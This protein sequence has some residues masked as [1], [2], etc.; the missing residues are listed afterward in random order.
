M[1][2][3]RDQVL[4]QAYARDRCE[5]SFNV[6]VR[7]HLDFVYST[8]LR[9]LR[10]STLAE[11]V[12]QVTF[13]ALAKNAAMLQQRASVTGWLHETTRHAAIDAVR[14]EE[15]RKRR[16]REAADMSSITEREHDT[17]AELWSRLAPHVDEGLSQLK[18]SD[19]DV[20]LWRYFERNTADEIGG[21]LDL[22][23]EAAQK[24]VA[25]ALERLRAILRRKGLVASS[26]SM[27][28]ALSAQTIQS[29]PA[30]LALTSLQ[31]VATASASA[32]AAMA[33][34]STAQI[35]VMSMNAKIGIAILLLA[36]AATPVLL[37]QQRISRLDAEITSL[38]QHVDA[39]AQLRP[40]IDRLNAEARELQAQRAKERAELAR[41]RAEVSNLRAQ[42]QKP[43]AAPKTASSTAS[44]RKTNET[45]PNDGLVRAEEI[46]NVG[47]HVPTATM[48][49]LEW[50]KRNGD[51]N[52]VF[53]ALAW[54]DENSR[55]GIQAI[56]AA[57][58]EAV[59]A[60]YGSADAYVL[61]LF[62]HSGPQGDR[63]TL[64]SYRIVEERI[65]GDEATLQ[66][67]THWADG[68][69]HTSPQRYVRLDNEWR[70]ALDFTPP[71]QGKIG[72]S[73][74]TEAQSIQRA[75]PG[76]N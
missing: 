66:I 51:T 35:I 75:P 3:E 8:A 16:E 50:A 70:Q 69:S 7:R 30:G 56:F 68:S 5:R 47:F 2:D 9:I 43:A 28:A 61:S 57:A 1:P 32:G 12:V 10:D 4:I 26:A 15:R 46:K 62:N 34:N 27:A 42:E 38:R 24:R 58:P 29:A 63:H 55:A 18:T 65:Q 37:Q 11:D 13:C 25:R 39:A 52:V 40:E 59:R 31:A 48:Q 60:R 33:A 17:S 19:R 36:G 44:Q 49:T 20:I 6:L 22:T 71:E 53:N 54:G 14:R 67:E 41:L 64:V 76:G 23:A 45:D 72:T 21:R 74:E 73:L